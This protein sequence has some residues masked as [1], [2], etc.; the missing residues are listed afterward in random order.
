MGN[1][2]GV[3]C[4]C[5]HGLWCIFFLLPH[6]N[7]TPLCEEVRRRKAVYQEPQVPWI[8]KAGEW[9]LSPTSHV[10]G[11]RA[12][13]DQPAR[14]A[15]SGKTRSTPLAPLCKPLGREGV[16]LQLL[17]KI[18]GQLKPWLKR[19]GSAQTSGRDAGTRAGGGLWGHTDP[20]WDL[21]SNLGP[22][23]SHVFLQWKLT[24]S[25]RVK[26]AT[27]NRPYLRTR[28]VASAK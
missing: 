26:G 24:V 27:C 11:K 1:S 25:I 23:G 17:E 12:R 15:W 9:P 16:K 13:L 28:P 7:L 5:V 22:V 20:Q 4:L 8:A 2:E 21:G 3:H 6:S 19:R 10:L 18:T 14:A